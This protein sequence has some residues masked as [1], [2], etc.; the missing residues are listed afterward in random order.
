MVINDL[1]TDS[2]EPRNPPPGISF[3]REALMVRYYGLRTVNM[4]RWGGREIAARYSRREKGEEGV[5]CW[6]PP[7]FRCQSATTHRG[8]SQTVAARRRMRREVE[9]EVCVLLLLEPIV[10]I[11]FGG[12]GGREAGAVV[13]ART[14]LNHPPPPRAVA[15]A[16]PATRL[17]TPSFSLHRRKGE[18]ER[19]A[20]MWP[21]LAPLRSA[22]FSPPPGAVTAALTTARL[23]APCSALRRPCAEKGKG[24][25]EWSCGRRSPGSTPLAARLALAAGCSG[26]LAG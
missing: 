16:P 20:E 17:A 1:R 19:G 26:L 22:L 21:P 12:V 14:A 6:H 15:A 8:R 25:K 5:H 4:E 13:A 2:A 11:V 10:V 24:R 7:C 9:E 18:R 23:A 3:G